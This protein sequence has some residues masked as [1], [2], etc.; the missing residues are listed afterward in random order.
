MP[1]KGMDFT[2]QQKTAITRQMNKVKKLDKSVTKQTA[3]FLPLSKKDLKNLPENFD[4]LE[5][6]NK[7]VFTKFANPTKTKQ[8]G[9]LVF[10]SKMGVRTEQ[11]YPF[12]IDLNTMDKIKN[13]VNALI[14]RLKPNY[15]RWS[16]KG[17]RGGEF[18]S[19]ETFNRYATD[20]GNA[21]KQSKAEKRFKED[22]FFNGVFLGWLDVSAK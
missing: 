7:G 11:F 9:K 18:F 17:Y 8:K 20:F 22:T 2:P 14:K 4:F 10:K 5:K 1:R 12:P 13:Y 19:P 15:V 21:L 6:T 16:V 3:G